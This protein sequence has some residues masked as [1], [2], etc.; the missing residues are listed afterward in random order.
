M[1]VAI[2]HFDGEEDTTKE[3]GRI[4][5]GEILVAN[6]EGFD[7]Y[8]Y[9]IQEDGQW[10]GGSSVTNESGSMKMLL[11]QKRR[12]F[13]R[14]Q[15]TVKDELSIIRRYKPPYGIFGS[16]RPPD[17]DRDRL[18]ELDRS[19]E[20]TPPQRPVTPTETEF[21][22]YE[23]FCD[24]TGPAFGL[25]IFGDGVGFFRG[26]EDTPIQGTHAFEISETTLCDLIDRC[27]EDRLFDSDH[28]HINRD[29][30]SPLP[31]TLT[32]IRIKNTEKWIYDYTRSPPESV[33]EIEHEIK[34]V[35]QTDL[36]LNPDFD[37]LLEVLAD[38]TTADG[39][40]VAVL[41]AALEQDLITVQSVDKLLTTLRPSLRSASLVTRRHAARILKGVLPESELSV[42][43]MLELLSPLLKS[44]DA[45]V[46]AHA[47]DALQ[48]LSFHSDSNPIVSLLEAED[49]DLRHAVTEQLVRLENSPQPDHSTYT[50]ELAA[51]LNADEKV[52]RQTA[53][54]AINQ[55]ISSNPETAAEFRSVLLKGLDD[56]ARD[57]R[58]YCAESLAITDDSSPL[59]ER[60]EA[61]REEVQSS[62]LHG[63]RELAEHNP[64]SVLGKITSIDQVLEWGTPEQ[65]K[66]AAAI[67]STVARNSPERQAVLLQRCRSL[68][69]DCQVSVRENGFEMLTEL[70]QADAQLAEQFRSQI[71]SGVESD[72]DTVREQALKTALIGGYNSL[73]V[74]TLQADDSDVR[75][76]AA[77]VLGSYA[78]DHPEQFNQYLPDVLTHVDDSAT[79]SSLT[80][81]VDAI[82]RQYPIRDEQVSQVVGKI[83]EVDT[84]TQ[85]ELSSTLASTASKKPDTLVP[86]VERL[87]VLLEDSSTEARQELLAC[88]AEIAEVNPSP[89]R[90]HIGPILAQFGD[91]E[92]YVRKEASRCAAAIC[93]VSQL[94]PLLE[95][96]DVNK[97]HA[98]S[99]TVAR[100]AQSS[101]ERVMDRLETIERQLGDLSPDELSQRNRRIVETVAHLAEYEP[102]Q[103]APLVSELTTAL[104]AQGRFTRRAGCQALAAIGQDQ[105]EPII[106]AVPAVAPLLN[107]Q[108]EDV[109]RAALH[110]LRPVA[111]SY[112]DE[113]RPAVPQLV[114]LIESEELAVETTST[115]GYVAKEYPEVAVPLIDR[116]KEWLTTEDTKL[117]NNALAS[118]TE[119]ADTYPEELL[120]E[121]ETYI[122]ML[123]ADDRYIQYNATSMV[124]RLSKSAPTEFED[125]VPKLTDLLEIDH[126]T[127]RSNACW[128]LGRI[129]ATAA[130]KEI[131]TLAETDQEEAVRAG[132]YAA[133]T[134][135][136]ISDCP[137]CGTPCKT[138][139]VDVTVFYP[140]Q[141][142]WTCPQCERTTVEPICG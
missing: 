25:A 131:T 14:P 137:H 53:A 59:I 95:S 117:R 36:W 94:E 29:E 124:A 35:C 100:I 101:P 135:F 103:I 123:D 133:L 89:L 38:G 69:G 44:E 23:P 85:E 139:E 24:D 105:V 76:T 90:E 54:E 50:E 3:L 91:E 126:S 125:A 99:W 34:K 41:D 10:E 120:D 84:E 142:Q 42:N 7:D 86:H 33:Q 64:D 130:R 68:V 61:D 66:S 88:L 92:Y 104:S 49:E 109:Q 9:P 12:V 71:E 17:E 132:A 82:V 58:R 96:S 73:A 11:D 141:V 75:R 98:A 56:P 77:R 43:S 32:G 26:W 107:D 115:L 28:T 16:I 83:E 1:V 121:A 27:Y 31:S 67:V 87:I 2:S 52:T 5:C 80:A 129:N 70:V 45:R 110:V 18:V 140:E 108:F 13:G 21:R 93:S 112:P 106:D 19:E 8:I 128:A 102:E 47:G 113:L 51:Q 46:A 48:T 22:L 65:R 15:L 74:E 111:K 63:L 4:H 62:A 6:T 79:R 78:V 138:H 39:P 72:S 55:I 60:L 20:I 81:V 97:S 114:D 118:L 30:E 134:L 127:T 136:E 122:E 116:Y 57:V 40:A 119:L 37:S